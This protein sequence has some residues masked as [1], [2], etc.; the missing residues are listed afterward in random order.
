[1][2]VCIP[3]VTV[4][5]LFW[6][7][8]N[9]QLKAYF[10]FGLIGICILGMII[11]FINL[12]VGPVKIFKAF[13]I[14]DSLVLAF[15]VTSLAFVGMMYFLDRGRWEMKVLQ[16]AYLVCSV[17]KILNLRILLLYMKWQRLEVIIYKIVLKIT[18][19]TY[20]SVGVY[21]FYTNYSFT[22]NI[23]KKFDQQCRY[24]VVL[25]TFA[26]FDFCGRLIKQM[27]SFDYTE[28]FKYVYVIKDVKKERV[29][30]K[31][32]MVKSFRNLDVKK[33]EKRSVHLIPVVKFDKK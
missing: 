22:F 31:E 6:S 15:G 33:K 10:G 11:T 18:A 19:L 28:K 9:L 16:A 3:P 24:F 14:L 30:K 7:T 2:M 5:L 13:I 32:Q 20:F 8:K 4:F 25:F 12:R 21:C 1:M 23:L 27:G 29:E 26:A 17:T